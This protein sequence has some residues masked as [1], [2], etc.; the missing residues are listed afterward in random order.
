MEVPIDDAMQA[1]AMTGEIAYIRD[2]KQI[3]KDLVC[4][5]CHDLLISARK[6]WNKF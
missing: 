5:D 4:S 3:E 6:Q 1:F 2:K